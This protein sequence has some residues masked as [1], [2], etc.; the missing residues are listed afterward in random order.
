[1]HDTTPDSY[2][3]EEATD[4]KFGSELAS[5]IK[6]PPPD[7]A[8]GDLTYAQLVCTEQ[9]M[10]FIYEIITTMDENG[11]LALLFKQGHLKQLGAQINHV[12]PLKFLSTIFKNPDLRKCMKGIEA[13]YFKWNGFMD[14]LGPSFNKEADKG[15]LE[16]YLKD[17]ADDL[18]IPAEGMRKYFQNKDWDGLARHIMNSYD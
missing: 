17:F 1:M 15:K 6:F 14:G 10:A 18:G 3:Y 5:I 4:S 13:D 9:D 12:H 2:Y 16:S 11:K 8:K 7:G